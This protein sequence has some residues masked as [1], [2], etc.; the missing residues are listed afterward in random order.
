MNVTGKACILTFA[1]A[2]NCPARKRHKSTIEINKFYT[3]NVLHS[4]NSEQ[5]SGL[6]CSSH[7][8]NARQSIENIGVFPSSFGIFS[9]SLPRK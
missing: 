2:A 4:S 5:K 3:A 9:S 1:I 7:L 8:V 6:A